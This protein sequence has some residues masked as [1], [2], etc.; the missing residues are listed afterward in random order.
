MFRAL[1]AMSNKHLKSDYTQHLQRIP[2]SGRWQ[3]SEGTLG[4][5]FVLEG[6]PEEAKLLSSKCWE[7]VLM[8]PVS[9]CTC[10]FC[11]VAAV[12]S[13]A[14]ALICK[15]FSLFGCSSFVLFIFVF[16]KVEIRLATSLKL[17]IGLFH[18]AFLVL[19]SPLDIIII[20]KI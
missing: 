2:S 18:S 5:N 10:Q 17:A 19:I 1:A 13:R 15:Y 8:I 16:S 12:E 4:L 6:F 14:S 9:H 7:V 11:K 20:T 3:T